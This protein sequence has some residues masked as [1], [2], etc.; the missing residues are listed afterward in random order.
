MRYVPGFIRKETVV[1]KL[2]VATMLACLW[3]LPQSASAQPGEEGTTRL[4]K[5]VTS[6][7]TE[8]V[9]YAP[10]QHS[11][12]PQY[13]AKTTGH[14]ASPDLIPGDRRRSRAPGHIAICVKG[15][16]PCDIQS[17]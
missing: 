8:G 15:E 17:T 3:A 13:M 12:I 6:C 14:T 2:A 4:L 11:A 16:E 1:S 7:V 5:G 9:F 10:R